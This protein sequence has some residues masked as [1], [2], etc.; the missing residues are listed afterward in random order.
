MKSQRYEPVWLF[1]F[2]D[3]PMDTPESR[4]DYTFFRKKLMGCG[5][6]MMQFSVYVRYCS[7]EQKANVHRTRIKKFLPPDGEVRLVS[8]TD[9]QFGKMQIFHGKLRKP[10]EKAPEQVEMF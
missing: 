10:P 9:I 2:F 6:T 4:R 1:A 3:L 7:S 8:I 5:F